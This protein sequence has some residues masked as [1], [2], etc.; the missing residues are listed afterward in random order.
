[1][2]RALLAPL[3][4]AAFTLATPLASGSARAQQ[5]EPSPAVHATN[6]EASLSLSRPLRLVGEAES[7]EAAGGIE[8]ASRGVWIGAAVGTVVGG[9]V[10]S[11]AFCGLGEG[12]CGFSITAAAPGMLIGG[13][14]GASIGGLLDDDAR[15]PEP[16][17]AGS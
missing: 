16:P 15:T 9:L 1:M 5:I 11:W 14:L 4:V 12:D 13:I 10:G 17:G 7:P 3:A 8:N 2:P 6:A